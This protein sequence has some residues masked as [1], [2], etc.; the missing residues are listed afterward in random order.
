MTFYFVDFHAD[1]PPVPPHPVVVLD[2]EKSEAVVSILTYANDY[3]WQTQYPSDIDYRQRADQFITADGQAGR[4]VDL[5]RSGAWG[6]F[7]THWQ[8]L[9]SNGARQGLAGLDEVAARLARTFGPRLLWMTNGQIA[10]YRAAEEACQITPM[11]GNAIRL[12]SPFACS[13]FTLTLQFPDFVGDRVRGV[14]LAGQGN[15]QSLTRE[16]VHDGQL[17]PGF[18]RQDGDC[19]TVC[20]DLDR[21]VQTLQL[22]SGSPSKWPEHLASKNP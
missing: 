20:F 11:A 15:A 13:D 2:R 19:I 10:R 3:F 5:V 1:G 6:V 4:L 18:W 8:S 17:M 9:Y 7:V 22:L 12:D 21:G 16:P 14:E